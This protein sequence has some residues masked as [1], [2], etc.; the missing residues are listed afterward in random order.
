MQITHLRMSGFQSFGPDATDIALSDVTYVLGPNGAGKT[1]V[2]EALSRLFS[3]L[4]AQR[5]VRH[6]DFHIPLGQTAAE[7]HAAGPG[8]W[9]EVDVEVPESGDPGDHVRRFGY[10]PTA[11]RC[12][13]HPRGRGAST[14]Y[15]WNLCR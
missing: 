2:L 11:N 5:K 7:V 14:R 13:C 12:G 10:L 1:A 3:P 15:W 9:I 4:S 8:L 6:S